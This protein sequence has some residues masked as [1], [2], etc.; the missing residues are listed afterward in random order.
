MVECT[1]T[2]VGWTMFFHIHLYV[3]LHEN[4]KIMKELLIKDGKKM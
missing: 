2:K 3:N 4:E 1:T